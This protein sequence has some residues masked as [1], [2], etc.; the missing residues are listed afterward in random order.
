MEIQVLGD[1][2]NPEV[3]ELVAGIP[4]R[5]G[6]ATRVNEMDCR[7]G[8]VR[9]KKKNDVEDLCL[10][11]WPPGGRFFL[12][13]FS[14]STFQSEKKHLRFLWA[15]WTTFTSNI[16]MKRT[17]FIYIWVRIS[18][19]KLIELSLE[20]NN[21]ILPVSYRIFWISPGH[22]SVQAAIVRRVES[23]NYLAYLLILLRWVV[24]LSFRFVR[25]HV[26]SHMKSS[27]N[28]FESFSSIMAH[29]S[30]VFGRQ[31]IPPSILKAS[32]KSSYIMVNSPH[33]AET[34]AMLS[35]RRPLNPGDGRHDFPNIQTAWVVLLIFTIFNSLEMKKNDEI[36][37]KWQFWKNDWFKWWW[38]GLLS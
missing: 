10:S 29:L 20:C 18:E 1:N 38:L 21:D 3:A 22:Q 17:C 27:S 12:P 19:H 11:W 16:R 37:L 2:P 34:A 32:Q 35:F 33:L 23:C 6:F 9:K 36:N 4:S 5:G 31:K 15:Q 30:A 8:G 28:H 26:K 25:I 7:E 13:R 24:F 14:H